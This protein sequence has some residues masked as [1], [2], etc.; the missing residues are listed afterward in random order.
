MPVHIIGTPKLMAKG[1]VF[2][3]SCLSPVVIS[4]SN[5]PKETPVVVHLT[6]I[7]PY[8][9]LSARTARESDTLDDLFV[10]IKIPLP[11]F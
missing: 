7:K 9:A 1:P 3:R 11:F 6:R 2:V 10:G 5:N 4:R 8:F